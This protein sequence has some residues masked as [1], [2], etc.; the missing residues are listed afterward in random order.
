MEIQLLGIPD[1]RDP[2]NNEYFFLCGI[3]QIKT[4]KNSRGKTCNQI[5]PFE[6]Q[7]N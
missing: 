2:R 7:I 3:R 1:I 5:S 4:L 6:K